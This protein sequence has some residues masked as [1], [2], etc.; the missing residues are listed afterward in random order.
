[1]L[2][3]LKNPIRNS[4]INLIVIL[5]IL[6]LLLEFFDY[7]NEDDDED[8]S[9]RHLNHPLQNHVGQVRF[10]ADSG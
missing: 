3:V 6:V 1:M 5:L 10:A 4:L 7:E 2:A 8:E 9:S